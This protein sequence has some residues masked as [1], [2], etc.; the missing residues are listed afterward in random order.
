MAKTPED[1]VFKDLFEDADSP[2]LKYERPNG[3]ASCV[4][5]FRLVEAATEPRVRID[6]REFLRSQTY[7]GYTGRGVTFT[8]D[9]IDK[10]IANLKQLKV[11]YF[12]LVPQ[13]KEKPAKKG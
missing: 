11:E 2:I 5:R 7:V 8:G 13:K 10:T 3:G 9:Q 4:T 1:K 12:K 6:I